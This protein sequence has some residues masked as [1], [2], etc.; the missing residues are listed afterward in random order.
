MVL[1]SHS[2]HL[3]IDSYLRL[4]TVEQSLT[5]III[6]DALVKSQNYRTLNSRD[7]MSLY[8]YFPHSYRF[9]D[10]PRKLWPF[11]VYALGFIFKNTIR[12]G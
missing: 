12:P 7:D 3:D 4:D 2:L 10:I 11:K 9:S 6:S 1:C 8:L 5:L